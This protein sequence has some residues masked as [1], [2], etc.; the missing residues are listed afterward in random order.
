MPIRKNPFSTDTVIAIAAAI[1]SVCAL[2]VAVYQTKLAREQQL[3]SVWPYLITYESM[4]EKRKIS[5][6]V[7]NQGIGPAIIDSVRLVYKGKSYSQPTQIVSDIAKGLNRGEFDMPW[8]HVRL[9]KGSVIPQG[10]I[11]S[12]FTV[13][14]S[15]DNEIFRRELPKIKSYIYYHSIYGQRW[16]ST[17]NDG[18]EVVV[19]D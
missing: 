16:H 19:E 11:V 9:I 8:S 18:D 1:T 10:Q 6:E 7:A 17:I 3:N 2:L 12:W 15:S 14:D 4:D 13:N 5:L